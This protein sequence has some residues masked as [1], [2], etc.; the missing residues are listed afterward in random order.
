[1]LQPLNIVNYLRNKEF[2][3]DDLI[4]L[5]EQMKAEHRTDAANTAIAQFN[6]KK[7]RFKGQRLK[8]LEREFYDLV[9]KEI[10]ESRKK[11]KEER[12]QEGYKENRKRKNREM[13]LAKQREKRDQ[14]NKI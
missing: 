6:E 2:T 11:H 14:A 10:N 13:W 12:A 8:R 9:L 4:K 7:A 1:M 5:L 3:E